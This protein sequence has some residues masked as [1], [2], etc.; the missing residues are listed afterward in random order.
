MLPQSQYATF[1]LNMKKK[2]K[3][4]MVIKKRKE[5]ANWPFHTFAFFP[6]LYVSN[7]AFLQYKALS[8]LLLLQIDRSSAL[9]QKLNYIQIS[10][11]TDDRSFLCSFSYFVFISL[12][13]VDER[14]Y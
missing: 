6:I 7:W 2:D 10:I 9:I 13:L 4:Y 14:D 3:K 5:N 11:N 1:S 8:L 12:L